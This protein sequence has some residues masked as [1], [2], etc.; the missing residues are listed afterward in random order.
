VWRLQ[1]P[2]LRHDQKQ[3]EDDTASGVQ[4]VLSFLPEAYGAQGN[5]VADIE[6][7]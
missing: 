2:Q 5:Q 7:V 1:K 6:G 4:E 3:E